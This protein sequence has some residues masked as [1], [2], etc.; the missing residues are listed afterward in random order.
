[1]EADVP[2]EVLFDSRERSSRDLVLDLMLP[3][4][5]RVIK[6]RAHLNLTDELRPSE[7]DSKMHASV[8]PLG[9]GV[10]VLDAET[11]NIGWPV[12]D[13]VPKEPRRKRHVLQTE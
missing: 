7:L 2:C 10:V 11:L 4:R 9:L 8:N 12:P 13:G 3:F 1:V 5:P 6:E